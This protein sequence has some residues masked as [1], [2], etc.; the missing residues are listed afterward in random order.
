KLPVVT[1]FTRQEL[2]ALL[3]TIREGQPRLVERDTALALFL[4]DTGAR[5]HE[6]ERLTVGD[7]DRKTGKAKVR[8]K[9]RKDGGRGRERYVLFAGKT[10]KALT[11]YWQTRGPLKPT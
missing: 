6:V 8:G 5:A 9:G 4:L 1:P 2:Q 11:R 3:Y 7:I 10:G